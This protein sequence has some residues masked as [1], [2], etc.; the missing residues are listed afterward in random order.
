MNAATESMTRIELLSA[1]THGRLRMRPKSAATPHFVQIVVNEFASACVCCPILLTKEAAT[2]QFYAGALFGFKPDESFLPEILERGGFNPLNL[3]RDG[4]FISGEDIALDRDNPRFSETEGEP[5]FDSS[6]QPTAGL[7]QIQ[8]ALGQLHAGMQMTQAFIREVA[9]LKLI[10]PI[11]VQLNFTGGERITLEGL[12]TVS[13]DR[14]R[15]L[16]D[17][18]ALSLLRSG[19]LQLAYTM[20]ASLKQIP[21]FAHLRNQAFRRMAART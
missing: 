13:L 19:Y 21:I 15:A 6:Q 11:D 3:Q 14:I 7:R 2:G 16:E 9:A 12:Y 8:R 18:S 20:N 4:F 17:A 5:L 1:D 10:E